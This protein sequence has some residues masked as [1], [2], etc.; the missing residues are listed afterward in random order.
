VKNKKNHKGHFA[1]RFIEAHDKGAIYCYAFIPKAHDKG[2]RLPCVFSKG[3][4]PRQK[5]VVRFFQ[6]RVAKAIDCR[7]FFPKAHGKGKTFPCVF[8]QHTTKA[9]TCR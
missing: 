4:L 8:Y 3:A 7:A 1:V 2:N 9:V 6:R 5:I